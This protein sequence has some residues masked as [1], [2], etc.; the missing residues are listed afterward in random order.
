[1]RTTCRIS[2]EPLKRVADLG[3]LYL[4][5]FYSSITAD[6][7]RG[8]LR[9][10]LGET[11]RLLQLEDSF[12]P[13]L[14]Y[15]EYWYRSGTNQ[16]MTGQL[17]DIV[18]TIPHWI[19][20]REQ[21]VVLDIGCNDGTL[22]KQY[23]D[24]PRL[25]TV[26]MDPARN[27]QELGQAAC[28]AHAAKYF[29]SDQFLPLSGGRKAKVIT[30]IA[31][32]YDLEDPSAFVRDIYESLADDGI[33]IAQLSYVPL[34]LKQNAFDNIVHEHLEFYSMY[35]VRYLLDQHDMKILDV[36]LN[37]V[38]AGSF[39]LIMSKKCNSAEDAAIFT[40]DI[41]EVRVR[42][43]ELLEDE[44]RLDEPRVYQQFMARVDEQK[45][46]L[47]ELLTRLKNEGKVVY[48]YGASSK[49]NTLLQYY[50]ITPDLV[51]AIA[52]R[53]PAKIGLYTPGSW[54]PIVSE[55]EMRRQRPDYLLVLPWH[56]IHEFQQRER[57][58]LE[59]GGQFIVPL[60]EVRLV[61]L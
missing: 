9:L 31:M 59:G 43:L 37:D 6:A 15:R 8:P 19:K 12:D 7:P 39:R 3:D 18:D 48:G 36:E 27:L 17:R 44:L 21:D 11:S 53:Q 4:T 24:S 45:N 57:A 22:L 26:G 5:G 30:S 25:F 23:P 10:S 29:S 1:M 28:D 33:W 51:T 41:G 35:P 58:F 50:G 52:E 14:L 42:S 54:I 55:E 60:P 34:M 40:R 56:F 47:L 49:G 13:D 16:T 61:G 32:F 46:R 20:L 2:G 38:N